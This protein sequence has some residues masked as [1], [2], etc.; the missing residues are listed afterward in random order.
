ESV[1]NFAGPNYVTGRAESVDKDELF[2]E[3]SV[4]VAIGNS[5]FRVK[6]L[7]IGYSRDVVK[8]GF[9]AGAVGANVTAYSIPGAIKPYYGSSPHAFYVFLRLRGHGEGMHDMHSMQK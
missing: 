9:V 5:V 6:A 7:T 8:T 1:L 2:A 4:P 3:Q